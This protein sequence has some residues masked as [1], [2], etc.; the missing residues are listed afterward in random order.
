[1]LRHV[2]K[3]RTEADPPSPGWLSSR[4]RMLISRLLCAACCAL[5]IVMGGNVREAI[6]HEKTAFLGR[7][8]MALGARTGDIRHHEWESRCLAGAA[9]RHYLYCSIFKSRLLSLNTE[10]VYHFNIFVLLLPCF[11]ALCQALHVHFF[12]SWTG[13]GP[14]QKGHF[15]P[16]EFSSQLQSHFGNLLTVPL[17]VQVFSLQR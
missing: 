1:M 13:H 4:P 14:H 16:L 9:S 10:T 17:A 2:L 15:Q 6:P 8:R 3:K 12:P 5:F 11:Q 7:G